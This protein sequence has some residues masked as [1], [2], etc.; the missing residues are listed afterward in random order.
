MRGREWHE[1][2]QGLRALAMTLVFGYHFVSL[3]L[4]GGRQL[5]HPVGSL[6]TDIFFV[7]AGALAYRSLIREPVSYWTYMQR[8]IWRIY[9]VY[10][11]VFATYVVIELV[12]RTGRM[13]LPATW[14]VAGQ[15]LS[16]ILLLTA[17]RRGWPI[18]DVTW[19]LHYIFAFYLFSPVVVW[20]LRRIQPEWRPVALAGL[21]LVAMSVSE[22][23]GWYPLR[24]TLLVAGPMVWA[25][26]RMWERSWVE[27]ALLAAGLAVRMWG[28]TP[29]L[30]FMGTVVAVPVIVSMGLAEDGWFAKF[31]RWKPLVWAGGRSYSFYLLHS[32]P[33]LAINRY[34]FNNLTVL[35]A[36]A[37]GVLGYALA[38]VMAAG[39]YKWV[40]EPLSRRG[41]DVCVAQGDSV[42]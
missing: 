33:L 9:P 24:T 38:L 31:L 40:E 22:T 39:M 21:W 28:T 3:T 13:P 16:D 41:R 26:R 11:I 12:L 29:E 25:A 10:L 32:L 14:G 42:G 2:L 8:R 19:A 1:S 6:G 17:L 27:V 15:Y 37:E 7:L 18:L 35:S 23:T 20:P 5:F 4:T 34:G 30:K 36:V